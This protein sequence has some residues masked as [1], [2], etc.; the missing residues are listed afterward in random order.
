M[1]QKKRYWATRLDWAVLVAFG[2]VYV[3]AKVTIWLYYDVF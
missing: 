3:I 2:I 1:K